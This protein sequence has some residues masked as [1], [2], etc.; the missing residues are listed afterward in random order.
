MKSVISAGDTLK[1]ITVNPM[2]TAN[3]KIS[4]PRVS[5]AVGA[6]PVASPS[7]TAA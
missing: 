7:S 4:W 5:S 6:S 3:A 1:T 2:A